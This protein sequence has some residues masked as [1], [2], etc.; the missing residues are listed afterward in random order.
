MKFE[1]KFITVKYNFLND[2][3]KPS[4]FQPSFPLSL[5]C[6]YTWNDSLYLCVVFNACNAIYSFS[7]RWKFHSFLLLPQTSL[8]LVYSFFIAI[9]KIFIFTL[10]V[11]IIVFIFSVT[12]SLSIS[13]QSSFSSGSVIYVWY[14]TNILFHIKIFWYIQQNTSIFHKMM[15]KLNAI[16]LI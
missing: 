1:V 5:K 7:C 2:K 11:F 14:H 9:S 4:H 13:Y 16:Y 6:V 15:L 12:C 10:F 8:F 3:C